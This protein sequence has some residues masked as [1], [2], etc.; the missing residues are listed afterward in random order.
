MIAKDFSEKMVRLNE[1]LLALKQEKQKSAASLE[2]VEYRLTLTFTLEFATGSG[3]LLY[4]RSSK[5][6]NISVKS[7]DERNALVGVYFDVGD[8]NSRLIFERM[9]QE[10]ESEN[11]QV[12]RL[13]F[14]QSDNNDDYA[15]LDAGKTVTVSYDVVV[16][17]TSAS[18]VSV[19]YED[20]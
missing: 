11:G 16:S 19:T 17:T 12:N 14:I 9:L 18:E 10:N 6:A 8:L 2:T 5:R 7:T 13:V 15:D 1:E 4:I 20:Y 3:G